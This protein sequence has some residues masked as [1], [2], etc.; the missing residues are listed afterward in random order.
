MPIGQAFYA[1]M[2]AK[3]KDC[4]MVYGGSCPNLCRVLANL[5]RAHQIPGYMICSREEGK[6]VES[7]PTT[8][9]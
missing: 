9:V 3:G 1:D 2:L 5:C 7:R 4:M 6:K 8:A